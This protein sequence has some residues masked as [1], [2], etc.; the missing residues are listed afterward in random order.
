MADGDGDVPR[1]EHVAT[2]E[3]DWVVDRQFL[4]SSWTC[5]W[6]RGCLGILDEPAE[7]LGPG[8]LLGGRPHRRRPTRPAPST[9]SP[10]MLDPAH[11]Q[12]HDGGAP[13]AACSATRP[14]PTPG[15]STARASS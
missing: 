7:H 13:R 4:E 3:V 9:P 11:F 15:W 6:G 1:W 2:A 5:I 10:R 12:F 8:L 14:P